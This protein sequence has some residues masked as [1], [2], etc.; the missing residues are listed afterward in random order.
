MKKALIYVHVLNASSELSKYKY[1]KG[2]FDDAYCIKWLNEEVLT[3][4][5]YE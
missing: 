2:L 1:L 3:H 5:N 4:T